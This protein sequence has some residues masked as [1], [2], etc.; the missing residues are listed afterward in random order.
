MLAALLL[1]L[2][3]QT[4]EIVTIVETEGSDTVAAE[5]YIRRGGRVTG[6]IIVTRPARREANYGIDLGEDGLPTGLRAEWRRAAA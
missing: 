1:A 6:R 5:T 4:V 3:L 2:P